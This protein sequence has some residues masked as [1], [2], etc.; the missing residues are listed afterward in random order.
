MISDK[1]LSGNRILKEGWDQRSA[2]VEARICSCIY[3]GG[4]GVSPSLTDSL[5]TPR[6]HND[7]YTAHRV[8]S[9]RSGHCG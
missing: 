1:M 8:G 4:C 6:V 5:G 2:V 9:W 3:P 7:F